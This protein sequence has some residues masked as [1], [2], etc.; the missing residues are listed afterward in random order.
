MLF[1]LFILF[2]TFHVWSG[3]SSR[4]VYL[5]VFTFRSEC[6]PGRRFQHDGCFGSSFTFQIVL[7]CRE[8]SVKSF[9]LCISP[10]SDLIHH[11]ILIKDAFGREVLKEGKTMNVRR[12]C[13]MRLQIYLWYEMIF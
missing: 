7:W 9:S 11:L 10:Q 5:A 6:L 2:V 13:D 12:A 3:F 4:D 1:H 8:G